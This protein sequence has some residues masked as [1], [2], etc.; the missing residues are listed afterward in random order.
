VSDH[1]NHTPSL[2]VSYRSLGRRIRSKPYTTRAFTTGLKTRKNNLKT[3]VLAEL[4]VA[5]TYLDILT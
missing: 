1:A 4:Q 5:S 3:V 2:L